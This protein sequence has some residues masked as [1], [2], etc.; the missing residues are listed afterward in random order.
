V[1]F[2]VFLVMSGAWFTLNT[3]TSILPGVLALRHV[4]SIVVTNAQLIENLIMMFV[5]VP[6]GILGQRIGRRT[7]LSLLG[8]AGCTIGPILYYVLVKSGYRSTVEIVVLV[9]L[10]NLCA[11]P[12]WAFVTAYINERFSTGVRACGYGIGYSAATI[13]PAF[14]SFYMLGLKA[15]G[16]PYEYTEVALFALGG[17]L[18]LVGALSGPETRHVEIS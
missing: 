9:T 8:L 6:F 18:L 17:L 10:I 5:F 16:M 13:I 12:V 15:L 7:V 2:Q 4:N 14:T 3:V 11:T 1:L